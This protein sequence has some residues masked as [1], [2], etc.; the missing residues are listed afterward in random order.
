MES[1]NGLNDCFLVGFFLAKL[2]LWNG[3]S[4]PLLNS[5][6]FVLGIGSQPRKARGGVKTLSISYKTK[7]ESG[8]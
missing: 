5:P 4:D 7:Q 3:V 6:L 8:M 2:F 1:L